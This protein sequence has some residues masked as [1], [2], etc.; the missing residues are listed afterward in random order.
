MLTGSGFM[1]QT[2][3]RGHRENQ[4]IHTHGDGRMGTADY[5]YRTRYIMYPFN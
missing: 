5:Q 4:M 1:L 3:T 2:S